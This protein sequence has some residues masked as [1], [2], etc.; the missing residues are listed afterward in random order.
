MLS[1]I[2]SG[3]ITGEP[4]TRTKKVSFN[5]PANSKDTDSDATITPTTIN[6]TTTKLGESSIPVKPLIVLDG[7]L[8]GRRA[9]IL[10]DDGCNTN[11][12]SKSF[13]KKNRRVFKIFKKRFEVCHSKKEMNEV[14]SEMVLHG[15]VVIGRHEYTSNWMST[16]PIGL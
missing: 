11:V 14:A 4:R 5:I 1:V 3:R 7:T 10:K 9:R 12:I 6:S 13:V 8:N 2:C 16:H 15:T